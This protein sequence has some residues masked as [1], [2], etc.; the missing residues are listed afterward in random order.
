MF[1]RR[2][3]IYLSVNR[4][5]DEFC[6]EFWIIQKHTH[7]SLF[8][9]HDFVNGRNLANNNYINIDALDQGHTPFEGRQR[10]KRGRVDQLVDQLLF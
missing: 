10:D 6:F 3:M 7:I 1:C 4:Y 5:R 9:V 8:C 2:C